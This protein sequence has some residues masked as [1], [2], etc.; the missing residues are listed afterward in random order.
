MIT[1]EVIVPE[2][3]TGYHIYSLG[4]FKSFQAIIGGF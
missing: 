4:E 2:T 3:Q 1:N